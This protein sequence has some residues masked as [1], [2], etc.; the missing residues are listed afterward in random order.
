MNQSS[1]AKA[2]SDI[3]KRIEALTANYSAMTRQKVQELKEIQQFNDRVNIIGLRKIEV[4][5]VEQVGNSLNQ[6]VRKRQHHWK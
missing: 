1:K 3:E 5:D 2:I 6:E 4:N